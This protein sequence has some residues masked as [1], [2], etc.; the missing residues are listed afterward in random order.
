MF[1]TVS[2]CAL[3]LGLLCI[4]PVVGQEDKGK[5]PTQ[6]SDR[7]LKVLIEAE[8]SR[9]MPKLRDDARKEY[10]EERERMEKAIIEERVRVQKLLIEAQ[11]EAARLR[12]QAYKDVLAEIGGSVRPTV[13]GG[14]PSQAAGIVVTA[15]KVSFKL[16]GKVVL[17][18][19]QGSVIIDFGGG[20]LDSFRTGEMFY[21][22]GA[23][24]RVGTIT[25]ERAHILAEVIVP[26]R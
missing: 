14:I 8:I 19:G 16:V 9:I 4:S 2:V 11:Q 23:S 5:D 10:R 18:A 22:E 20:K 24:F 25:S 7:Y 15:P 26:V 1:R 13:G 21:F 17:G 3:C 12:A 6:P